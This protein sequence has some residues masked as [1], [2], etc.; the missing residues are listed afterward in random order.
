VASLGIPDR[1]PAD[2]ERGT[3]DTLR[4]RRRLAERE[5]LER[6]L[7]RHGGNV[8]AAAKALAISR[9]AFYKA[10]RRSGIPAGPSTDG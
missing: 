9:Q 6:V 2:G 3:G 4:D 10:L 8:T 7:E 1:V 5:H